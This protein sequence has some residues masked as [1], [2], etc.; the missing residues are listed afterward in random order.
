[1]TYGEFKILVLKHIDQYTV[2]GEKVPLS[3]NNQADFVNKIPELTNIV[4]RMLATTT[5][6][7]TETV[8]ASS[9]A[10]AMPMPGGWSKITLPKDFWRIN[11]SGLLTMEESGLSINGNY[12]FLTNRDLI[13][14][15][16]E[17]PSMLIRYDRYPRRVK[18]VD[19]ETLDCD[20]AVA[21]CASF[22]V[23]AQLMRTEDPYVY[24]SMMN[25]YSSMMAQIAKPI[26]AEYVRS[27]DVYSVSSPY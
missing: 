25:E 11:G 8:A 23:G 21:D 1:M 9:F 2:A 16:S 4:L 12:R 19:N 20:D 27:Q 5:A 26:T 17:I 10:D 7:L 6:P 14:R 13:V 24:Q 15:T 3:Y 22:Y 18:G